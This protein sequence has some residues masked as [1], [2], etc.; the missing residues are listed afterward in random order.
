MD[1]PDLFMQ[2]FLVYVETKLKRTA[3]T[4][5]GFLSGM[6]NSHVLTLI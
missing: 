2:A 5:V 6:S 4:I 1:D 3:S